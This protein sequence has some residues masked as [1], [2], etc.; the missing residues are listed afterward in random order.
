[1]K[2]FISSIPLKKYI[3]SFVLSFII[4]TML[5]AVTGFI[6][7]RTTPSSG[8]ISAVSRYSYCM[9]AFITAILCTYGESNHGLIKGIISSAIYVFLLFLCGVLLFKE[10]F[11]VSSLIKAIPLATFFGGIGGIFGINLKK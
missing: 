10:P 1:M 4:T 5:L 3:F 11:N 8:V 6:F 2:F 7:S 9:S